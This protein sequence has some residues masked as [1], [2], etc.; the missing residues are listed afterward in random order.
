MKFCTAWLAIVLLAGCHVAATAEDYTWVLKA[1]ST[2]PHAPHSRLT[3][4]V[5]ASGADGRHVS[6]IPFV[7][8]VDWVGVRGLNHNGIS[9]RQEEILVKGTTGTAVLR[10]LAIDRQNQMKEVARS[11]VEVVAPT[12]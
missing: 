11:T 2:V 12:P 5:E 4:S 8:M 10:I 9:D 1:P 7:W 3:F 6:G